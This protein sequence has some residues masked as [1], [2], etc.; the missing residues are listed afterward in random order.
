L[1][2]EARLVVGHVAMRNFGLVRDRM[3]SIVMHAEVGITEQAWE[4]RES[5]LIRV[6]R[7][8]SERARSERLL[9][10]ELREVLDDA[11]DE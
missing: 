3:R 6:R 11:M 10:E 2:E 1:D 9:D 7:L 5:Q 4:T 8:Q